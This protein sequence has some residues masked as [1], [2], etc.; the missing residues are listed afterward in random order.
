MPY[1]ITHTK[2]YT[3]DDHL[4]AD[5]TNELRQNVMKHLQGTTGYPH[6]IKIDGETTNKGWLPI[7]KLS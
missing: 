1:Q 2:E 6:D 3:I 4:L 7:E 5:N